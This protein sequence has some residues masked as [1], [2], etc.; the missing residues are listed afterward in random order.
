MNPNLSDEQIATANAFMA[1]RFVGNGAYMSTG[2]FVF[3]KVGDDV[4]LTDNETDE[5]VN[6]GPEAV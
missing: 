1:P 4:I 6:L 3:S 5:T 2:Q